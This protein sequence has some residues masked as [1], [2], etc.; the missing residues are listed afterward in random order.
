MLGTPP[1]EDQRGIL[2]DTKVPEAFQMKMLKQQAT[3]TG[4]FLR[5][6]ML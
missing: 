5:K 2:P 1:P 6:R 3:Q 4:R